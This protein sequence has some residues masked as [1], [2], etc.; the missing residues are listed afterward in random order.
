LNLFHRNKKQA[1]DLESKLAFNDVNATTS[2]TDTDTI[3]VALPPEIKLLKRAEW[4]V[5]STLQLQRLA[6][7][8]AGFGTWKRT[9]DGTPVT[10]PNEPLGVLD[11]KDS[12]STHS[13]LVRASTA[14]E[15]LTKAKPSF[16]PT[17]LPL[18]R[19]SGISFIHTVGG[20][21]AASYGHSWNADER[22]RP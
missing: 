4:N 16:R 7:E 12:A 18:N 17:T 20:V 15:M 14:P 10:L 3:V 13:H 2:R 9:S 8:G 19:Y 1:S 22:N 11:F 6:H 21:G 5:T